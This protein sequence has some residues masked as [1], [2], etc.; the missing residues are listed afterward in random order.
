VQCIEAQGYTYV[1]SDGVY[2]DTSR[3]SNY[4]RLA[5][6]STRGQRAG[7][8]VDMGDKRNHTDFALWKFSPPDAK[9]QMEWDSPWGV[10]FPGWH[11]ECSAMS[12]K[13]LGSI[14][15][16]H[17][18]G[19]DHIAVHHTNEIAQTQACYGT[20]LANYWLHGYFLQLDRQKMSK[21]AGGFIRLQDLIDQGYDPLAYRYFLLGGHYRSHLHFHYEG[22]DSAVISLERL[23][24]ASHE[25][26]TPGS[27][28]QD[29]LDTFTA[30][31][32]DDLNMP[33]ALAVVWELA[34]SD[35]D[36]AVKKATLLE[37]DRV[38]GLDLAGWE[39]TEEEIPARILALVDA[40]QAARAEK[41]WR[42]ADRLRDQILAAGFQVKD[43]P[44]GPQVQEL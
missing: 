37:L 14:F 38:L 16:I 9:R 17:C 26:G 10:G 33:R 39:P 36:P 23:R 25:W 1:T 8:R 5:R 13:Y 21:S 44:E 24:T 42:D 6:L 15:D 30:Q 32:N 19:E 4:G 40:R 12:A 18:G 22:L 3:L 41:R 31:I 7:A 27:P 20:N 29:C 35:Q 28:D 11:V 2:F 34:R 43:T